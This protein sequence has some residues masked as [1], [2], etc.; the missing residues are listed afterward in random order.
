MKEYSLN[1]LSA[2]PVLIHKSRFPFKIELPTDTMKAFLVS[3]VED[4]SMQAGKS[5]RD[6]LEGLLT[7]GGRGVLSLDFQAPF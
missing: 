5:C 3:P 1:V 6:V 7:W 4:Q 2:E